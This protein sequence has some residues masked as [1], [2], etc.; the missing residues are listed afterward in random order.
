MPYKN[1]KDQ[2]DYY[3][4]RH[5]SNAE[6]LDKLRN[7]PCIDC[8][9]IFPPYVMEF[10]HVPERG[11]KKKTIAALSGS[12]KISAPTMMTELKKCD[13]I[14]ANCHK[15]RTYKRRMVGVVVE[16]IEKIIFEEIPDLFA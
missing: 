6:L 14:C 8:N 10:D 13:L 2:I 16:K 9:G 15:I 11:P 3:R 5:A 4:R 12:R 1:Y 7:N